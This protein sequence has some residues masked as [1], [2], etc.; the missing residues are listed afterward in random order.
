[1]SELKIQHLVTLTGLLSRGAKNNFVPVT[2]TSLGQQIHK[3]QQAAS[4]HLLELEE[5]GFIERMMSGRKISVRLTK[6][7]Y[8]QISDVFN[9]LK[10]SMGAVN[11]IELGGTLVS[12]MGEGAYYMSLKGYT[13]QFKTKIG[14]IPFP[15][16]LN[17]RLDKKEH[18]EAA[19]QLGSKEGI[20]IDGFS[21]GRRTYGWVKCYPC[22]INGKIDCQ[23]ILLERTH[24]D[25]SVIE[26]ISETDIRKRLV[27]KNGAH[28]A[29]KIPTE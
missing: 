19:R 27:L 5:A 22:T 7:G 18:V 28:L 2:T 24:H 23:L 3:S 26:L 21:D 9:L 25:Y 13:K 29:I 6:K 11:T 15:G 16:T 12:G 10:N 14:Y 8:E 1:M 17:V 20:K 4:Q